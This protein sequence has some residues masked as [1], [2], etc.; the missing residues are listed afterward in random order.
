MGGRSHSSAGSARAT[1]SNPLA[2]APFIH[3]AQVKTLVAPKDYIVVAR[4]VWK[5][6]NNQWRGTSV[7]QTI[8][9]SRGTLF[10]RVLG[11]GERFSLAQQQEFSSYWQ[12]LWSTTASPQN[13]RAEFTVRYYVSLKPESQNNTP[14]RPVLKRTSSEGEMLKGK[15]RA[16]M[17]WSLP[18]LQQLGNKLDPSMMMTPAD[19]EAL[20]HPN[21]QRSKQHDKQHHME[22]NV[23]SPYQAVSAARCVA[24]RNSIVFA[25]FCDTFVTH[26]SSCIVWQFNNSLA[27]RNSP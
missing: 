7:Q 25:R 22:K 26:I 12:K 21:K 4:L 27:R 23:L 16:G 13:K 20:K 5:N 1:T 2:M 8:T 24:N 11:R 9:L 19:L 10:D 18:L 3:Q 15:I 6:A 17:D 14:L